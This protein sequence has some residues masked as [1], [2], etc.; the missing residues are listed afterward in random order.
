MNY[1]KRLIGRIG[2]DA[3][4]CWIGDPCYVIAK[5]CDHAWK[6]WSSFL[7]SLRADENSNNY[8]SFSYGD[9]IGREGLGV[10]VSTGYGDGFYPVTAR[11]NEEGRVAS[12][13]AQF[14]QDE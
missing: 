9:H 6:D 13:T 1:H 10:C 7:T 14:L 8:K 2:V 3:G 4:L 11:F 12:V 5:D